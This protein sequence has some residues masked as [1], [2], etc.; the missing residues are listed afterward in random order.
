[1]TKQNIS[2]E[3]MN[4]LNNQVR[5][6]NL[7]L[8]NNKNNSLDIFYR[9][10]DTTEARIDEAKYNSTYST[11]TKVVGEKRMERT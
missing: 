11:K 1:M 7:L 9:R 2:T 10:Q 3:N 4:L 6:L 5:I 8:K